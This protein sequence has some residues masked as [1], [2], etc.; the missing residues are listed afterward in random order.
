[1]SGFAAVACALPP[2]AGSLA[3]CA[4]QPI[5]Q[6]VTQRWDQGRS[7]LGRASGGGRPKQT[8]RFL[9]KAAKAFRGAAKQAVLAGKHG[10]LSPACVDALRSPL[11]DAAVRA[12]QLAASL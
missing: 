12:A 4:G 9:V 2:D 7:L 3:A 6:A 11:G 10:R 8:R 1:V 5:P